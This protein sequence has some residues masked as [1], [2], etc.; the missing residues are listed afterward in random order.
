M[1]DNELA[2]KHLTTAL[3]LVKV[4]E[5][6][7][8]A[9]AKRVYGKALSNMAEVSYAEGYFPKALERF[10]YAGTFFVDCPE[11]QAKIHLFAAYIAGSLGDAD[12][13]LSE[14]TQALNLYQAVNNK[15]GEGF[16][17]SALGQFHSFK[18]RQ[19]QAIQFHSDAIKIF[20]SVG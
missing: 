7:P 3:A 20:R 9:T 15:D 2:K 4:T 18:G 19:E 10:K 13:A 17:L 5:N 6:D 11:G 12:A 14:V 16:A 1:G 8:D